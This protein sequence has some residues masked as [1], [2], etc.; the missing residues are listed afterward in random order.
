M[1]ATAH[2]LPQLNPFAAHQFQA[3]STA[4]QRALLNRL[5]DYLPSENPS[6]KKPIL[7][8]KPKTEQATAP[9]NTPQAEPKI[10]NTQT[11]STT[12]ENTMM[13]AQAQ[14][15]VNVQPN[16]S[17]TLQSDV[18]KMNQLNQQQTTHL[19]SVANEKTAEPQ[20]EWTPP[21]LDAQA[22][23]QAI[24]QQA[25]TRYH[26]VGR[27]KEPTP[28][29]QESSTAESPA[30]GYSVRMR[31]M[32][33]DLPDSLHR[34]IKVYCAQKDLQVGLLVRSLLES[35]FANHKRV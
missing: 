4:H 30:Q 16:A 35:C 19:H 2:P 22:L 20:A 6:M 31:R 15:P 27:V 14:A 7:S 26:Q 28:A 33:I 21:T 5:A 24:L 18:L 17:T 32:T 34:D 8:R 11:S 23:A 9:K 13:T 29:Q 3:R 1:S 25:M 12:Q 10:W